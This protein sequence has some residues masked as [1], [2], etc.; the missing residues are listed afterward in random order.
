[1]DRNYSLYYTLNRNIP[2][3]RPTKAQENEL[4]KKLGNLESESKKAVLRLI[5]EHSKVAEQQDF[6]GDD[7]EI[8]YSGVQNG[9]DVVFDLAN[10]PNELKWILLKFVN[11]GSREIK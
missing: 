3:T 7:I 1:M 2:K 4:K 5:A 9:N 8:P 11:L 10:F 6:D